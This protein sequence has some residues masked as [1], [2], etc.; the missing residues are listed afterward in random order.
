MFIVN[1]LAEIPVIA[2]KTRYLSSL[3]EEDQI[4]HIQNINAY[5][6]LAIPHPSE[7]VQL[8]A[9]SQNGLANDYLVK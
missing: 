7:E 9:V 5:D 3:C 2:A 4:K 8:A 6:V 1:L